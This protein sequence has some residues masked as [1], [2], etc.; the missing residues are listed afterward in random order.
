MKVPPQQETKIRVDVEYSG[1]E[2]LMF[3][4]NSRGQIGFLSLLHWKA[5]M[6]QGHEIFW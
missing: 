2:G 1:G 6:S 5:Q 3:Y 4:K